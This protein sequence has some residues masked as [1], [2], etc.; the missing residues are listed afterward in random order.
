M[1]EDVGQ[2]LVPRGRYG[3]ELYPSFMRLV[4]KT[5]EFKVAYKSIA[6]MFYLLVV[7]EGSG[8]RASELGRGRAHAREQPGP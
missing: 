2:F 8:G 6:R 3:I 1:G 4:G 5:Y 7:W